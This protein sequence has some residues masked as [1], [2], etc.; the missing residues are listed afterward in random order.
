MTQRPITKVATTDLSELLN[1]KGGRRMN[2]PGFDDEFVDFPDYIVRITD[3]I[4]HE[5]QVELCL[6]Y[7]APDSLIHT[8]SGQVSGAQTVVD[9]TYATLEAFP[10]RVLDPDN[11]IWSEDAPQPGSDNPVFYS[12][13]LITSKMT[14]LGPS[15]FGDAT[16]R[17]IKVITIADC[18]CRD[19]VVF[20]EWLVRDYA[21]VVR[22][23]GF[24]VDETTRKLAIRDIET[25]FNLI[26]HHAKHH[27]SVLRAPVR[28]TDKPDSA[29]KDPNAFAKSFFSQIWS[30][31][32]SSQL[33]DFYD[34]RVDA[35]YP[36]ER[37][38]YGH[39]QIAPFLHDLFAAIPD[40]KMKVEHVADIPYLENTRDIAVRWSLA[41][42]HTGNG[43]YGEATGAN[44]Y[45]MGVSH[46]R[47]MNGRIRQEVTIW[48]DVAVRRM[49][50]GA[51]LRG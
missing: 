40:T 32:V 10:D 23:M 11:V 49:I 41:G 13:H 7:Y 6:K 16:G 27:E 17:K 47:V 21:T 22:Q 30:D 24:D 1:P 4:W 31:K 39:D 29:E 42:T 44:V 28:L 43:F 48:D 33:S 12:S 45:I 2:L 9:N 14:N 37:I 35:T 15:E 3:R 5:R 34:F 26:A 50:E 8:Q 38:F 51:R 19:N 25:G 18:A 20:E 46:F 36:D